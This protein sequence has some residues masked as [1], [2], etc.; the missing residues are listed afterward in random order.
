MV[1][2]H[3]S[4]VSAREVL[5]ELHT[6]RRAQNQTPAMLYTIDGRGILLH[7]SDRWC[8]QL[9]LNREIVLGREIFEFMAPESQGRARSGLKDLFD[10]GHLR[11]E[12]CTFVAAD[13]SPCRVRLSASAWTDP[14]TAEMRASAILLEDGNN[15][16]Q[17]LEKTVERLRE[18]NRDLDAFAGLVA[19]DLQGPLRKVL[20]ACRTLAQGNE[21]DETLGIAIASAEQM[22]T[23]IRDLLVY[24]RSGRFTPSQLETIDLARV[25][26]SAAGSAGELPEDGQLTL[27]V[28]GRILSYRTGL[29]QILTNLLGNAIR[30]RAH[31]RPL[32]I[33]VQSSLDHGW[34]TLS[35]KDNGVGIAEQDIA[36]V[37][38]PFRR[39]E[40]TVDRPGSGIG[41][42]ICSKL[43][44]AL[45]GTLTVRSELDAGSTFYLRLPLQPLIQANNEDFTESRR[46]TRS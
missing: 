16:I 23:L 2:Q 36:T 25:C 4:P 32:K 12:P 28:S 40:R 29:H 31:E 24:A 5:A 43:S 21:D 17:R 34:L 15:D 14:A 45:G 10:S 33:T 3:A 30:Y 27:D 8:Q 11:D 20:W 19:H 6:L 9:G 1:Y 22:Q 42:A 37:F 26:E 7:V 18:R 13:G 35:V 38:K 41:L 39:L 46:P 44:T